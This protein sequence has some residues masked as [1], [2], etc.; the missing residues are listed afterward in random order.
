MGATVTTKGR[1]GR[2]GGERVDVVL[3]RGA[4]EC[5]AARLLKGI[6]EQS[7]A[8]S[9][10]ARASVRALALDVGFSATDPDGGACTVSFQ[11]IRVRIYPGLKERCDVVVSGSLLALGTVAGVPTFRGHLLPWSA[12]ALR[13]AWALL[14][15]KVAVRRAGVRF[16]ELAALLSVLSVE[17][18]T[19]PFVVR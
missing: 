19:C 12:G 18:R 11:G 14:G 6:L 3:E 8:A 5:G 10:Y 13:V 9:A 16:G 7:L 17:Q 15:G 4:E 2:L 1:P